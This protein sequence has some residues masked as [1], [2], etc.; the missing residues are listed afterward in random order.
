[1]YTM[2][3]D[4]SIVKFQNLQNEF[5][6]TMRQYVQ[7]QQDY[8][9]S[10]STSKDISTTTTDT[11]SSV[12]IISNIKKKSDDL[13]LLNNTLINLTQQ[14][15][16]QLAII[17]P[18]TQSQKTEQT[19]QKQQLNDIYSQLQADRV[20]VKKELDEY[21]MLDSLYTDN[22]IYVVQ[23]NYQY[24]FWSFIA[25]IVVFYMFKM[26][27][28][29]ESDLPLFFWIGLLIAAHVFIYRFITNRF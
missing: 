19:Q 16:A 21:Q 17:T 24:L 7:A 9:S 26:L 4:G 13:D 28:F 22:S 8:I 2:G 20:N 15:T 12:A 3:D 25:I 10:L 6:T 18:Q 11:S 23:T 14:L 27:A 1:M 29:P 5:N